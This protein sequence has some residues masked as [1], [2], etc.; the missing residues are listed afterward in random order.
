V[1]S[2]LV[3]EDVLSLL[4]MARSRSHLVFTGAEPSIYSPYATQ[5][6]TTYQ[7][8]MV[9][10]AKWKNMDASAS[11]YMH[12]ASLPLR[13]GEGEGVRLPLRCESP[14]LSAAT[15]SRFSWAGATMPSPPATAAMPRNAKEP[16]FCEEPNASD[17]I[18]PKEASPK[19]RFAGQATS[20]P[21]A[22]RFLKEVDRGPNP[23]G[24][25]KG[26][27][28]GSTVRGLVA[29]A[30]GGPGGPVLTRAQ[31][32]RLAE[33]SSRRLA[34]SR[35]HYDDRFVTANMYFINDAASQGGSQGVTGAGHA[36][37]RAGSFQ[38]LSHPGPVATTGPSRECTKPVYRASK[39]PPLEPHASPPSGHAYMPPQSP[40]GKGVKLM[41]RRAVATA[42]PP[43]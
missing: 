32:K 23:G 35:D 14:P 31:Q 1:P 17:R 15:S 33:D 38:P 19:Q 40:E 42:L 8:H 30:P 16:R 9:P 26:N 5:N 11:A 24:F 27:D 25:C 22:F 7:A 3:T 36:Q 37:E 20:P 18:M 21:F 29:P 34:L 12:D 2:P 41:V 4:T 13:G 10:A 6:A 28:Q 43:A 39:S